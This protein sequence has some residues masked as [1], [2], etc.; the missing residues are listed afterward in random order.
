[1]R[2]LQSPMNLIRLGLTDGWQ[3]LIVT[4]LFRCSIVHLA[5]LKRVYERVYAPTTNLI[6]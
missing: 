2:T 6:G 3:K 5:V 1:M 4:V